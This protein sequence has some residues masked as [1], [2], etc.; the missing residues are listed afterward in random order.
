MI[1]DSIRVARTIWS[2]LD[3]NVDPNKICLKCMFTQASLSNY[4]LVFRFRIRRVNNTWVYFSRI[5]IASRE[6][7]L[8]RYDTGDKF[9]VCWCELSFVG[10]ET[11]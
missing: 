8:V 6:P 5:F 10:K 4:P 7:S 9:R 2:A 11:R 3:G 1:F